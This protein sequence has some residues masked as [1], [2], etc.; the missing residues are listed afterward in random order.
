MEAERVDDIRLAALER[1]AMQEWAEGDAIRAGILDLCADLRAVRGL[2][3]TP[4]VY[5]DG[6]QGGV[7]LEEPPP[8]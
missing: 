8:V 4:G 5:P 7:T 2:P 1:V 6:F 3:Q